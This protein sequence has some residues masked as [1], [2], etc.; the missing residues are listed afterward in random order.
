MKRKYNTRMALEAMERL[1]KAIPEAQ[2]TTDMIAGFPGESEKEFAETL[3]FIEKARFLMIHAFPYSRRSGTV[4]DAMPDQIP[5]EIKRERVG[6][7]T[8]LQ[9]K[10]R[11]QILQEQVGK[12]VSVLFETY[13]DGFAVGHTPNFIEVACP[14]KEPLHARVCEVRITGIRGSGCVGELRNDKTSP[15]NH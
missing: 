5:E 11:H 2:F 3:A 10:I 1:R 12:T 7:I 9:E 8:A 4:A 6:R 13:A 15:L 14:S